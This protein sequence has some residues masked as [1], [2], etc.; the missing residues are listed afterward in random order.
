[1]FLHCIVQ[2]GTFAPYRWLFPKPK[3]LE[4]LDH[5]HKHLKEVKSNHLI[6]L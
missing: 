6:I 3:L 2:L 5:P 1:M 4:S